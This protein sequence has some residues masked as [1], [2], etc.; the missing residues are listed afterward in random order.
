MIIRKLKPSDLG[1]IN[2]WLK[3]WKHAEVQ[4]ADMPEQSLIIP[5]VASA[6]LRRC[7]GQVGIVDSI[8]TN[9]WASSL[10]RNAAL[11]KLFKVI[12]ESDCKRLIGFSTDK[13]TL[14]RAVKHGFKASP[15]ITMCFSKE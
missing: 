1:S 12:T 4:W 13:H 7:E 6:S 15:Y 10:T 2:K 14:E 5:G 9:P 8:V 11:N 3:Q